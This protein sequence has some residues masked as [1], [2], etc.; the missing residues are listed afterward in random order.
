M[1]DPIQHGKKSA[2]DTVPTPIRLLKTQLHA[3]KIVT[4]VRD[5]SISGALRGLIDEY[6]TEA[7]KDPVLAALLDRAGV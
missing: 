4:A 7:R 5:E 6:L 2:A 1:A 3:L